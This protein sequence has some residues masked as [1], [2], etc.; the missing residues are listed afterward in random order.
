MDLSRRGF[1]GR[2]AAFGAAGCPMLRLAA[3]YAP[4]RKPRLTFGV[5]SDIH[6]RIA[7]D[8]KVLRKS[9][10]CRAFKHAL[11]WFRDQNV[12]AVMVAGDLADTGLVS[13]LQAVADTW[14]KVFPGSKLPGGQHVERVFIT[15]NHDWDAWTYD[16]GVFV[17]E[18]YPDEAERNRNL[19][20]RDLKGNWER[21]MQEPYVPI[22]RK[23]VNGYSFVGAHWQDE[24]CHPKC[25]T[26]FRHVPAWFEEHGAELDPRK[27]FFYCQHAHLQN[28]VYG[29]W[30]WGHDSGETTAALKAFPNAVAF[31]GHSHYILTDERSIW[32]GGFTSLGTASL[33]ACT[34]PHDE[35]PE[36]G[37]ENAWG[38]PNA[39]K[40]MAPLPETSQQG[41]LV[42]VF[43]DCIAFTRR[44]FSIDRMIGGDW[45]MPL[46]AAK[47]R[48]FSFAD[49]RAKQK[50]PA[51]PAGAALCAAKVQATKRGGKAKV[52]GVKTMV[53]RETKDAVRLTFPQASAVRESRPFHY[54]ATFTPKHGEAAVRRVLAKRICMPEGD[55]WADEPEEIT[56]SLDRLPAAPLKIEL[57]AVSAFGT[58]SRPL[59]TVFNG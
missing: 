18:L 39:Y 31:S 32:Q 23:E 36:F 54:E 21:I 24:P 50:P 45:V 37:Y 29:S 3:A 53:P 38:G 49:R 48:P 8:G 5:V 28:T 59:T 13:E 10:D 17:K 34:T 22:Y 20:F 52:N 42:R 16:G 7:P 47:S 41:M 19:L 55:Y 9:H 51:F 2:A 35:F 25:E 30:A 33:R 46:P 40:T 15:G 58:K 56:V 43:D 6:V 26:A 27:P 11:E 14:W 57:C 1:I 4:G 44:D 12:D